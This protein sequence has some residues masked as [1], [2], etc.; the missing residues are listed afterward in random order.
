MDGAVRKRG[1][2]KSMILPR[3]SL[4]PH[5]I[6]A[7]LQEDPAKEG[8]SMP[9]QILAA[10]NLDGKRMPMCKYPE[11]MHDFQ[12]LA[13]R[14]DTVDGVPVEQSI[15]ACTKCGAE[16]RGDSRAVNQESDGLPADSAASPDPW[17]PGTSSSDGVLRYWDR[18]AKVTPHD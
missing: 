1:W 13:Q 16:L 11:Q 10:V 4:C 6:M 7:A 14:I 2:A 12:R 8:E 18:R 9:H 15:L 3:R 17:P 5:G